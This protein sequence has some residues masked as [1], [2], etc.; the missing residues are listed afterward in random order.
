MWT[1]DT[2][3]ILWRLMIS[4][5]GFI[6]GEDRNPEHKEAAF[7]C[8]NADN[9]DV[10]WE[11]RRFE[12]SWWIGVEAV[13]RDRVY[14]HGFKKP[15]S[16]QHYKIFAVDLG[17]GKEL[18]RNE[19]Y[20]FLYATP[21]K[22]VVFKEMF[23]RRHLFE[24][25]AATGVRLGETNETSESI[26]L[27][28]MENCGQTDFLFPEPLLETHERYNAVHPTIRQHCPLENLRGNIEFACAFG[29]IIAS[30]HTVIP[31]SVTAGREEL[32]N[33]LSIIDEFKQSVVFSE[34]LNASTPAAVPDSF[35]IDGSMLFCVKERRTL[36][37]IN[38]QSEPR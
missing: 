1:Y 10:L 26:L 21:D 8:L 13:V 22:V 5:M 6:L 3:G 27:H 14:M 2:K 4:E 11:E 35:F 30:F 29:K 32:K 12:E 17:T 18:W 31:G 15:D 36:I 24:L 16:P 38:L 9:G 34:V 25:D 7:F 23:E 20:S 37:A 28:R 33:Q 19:E